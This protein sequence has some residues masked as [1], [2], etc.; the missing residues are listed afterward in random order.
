M[1]QLGGGTGKHS[2]NVLNLKAP[3]PHLL[4]CLHLQ[5]GAGCTKVAKHFTKAATT[6]LSCS[7]LFSSPDSPLSSCFRVVSKKKKV[8]QCNFLDVKEC[9]LFLVQPTKA[10]LLFVRGCMKGFVL[11]GGSQP[12]LVSMRPELLQ[13]P[14]Q[15]STCFCSS[16]SRKLHTAGDPR[17]VL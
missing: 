6:P 4:L 13:N 1:A 17:Q 9:F 11:S 12:V 5:E 3:S 14:L 7:F 8:S 15:I 2:I 16:L 10:T